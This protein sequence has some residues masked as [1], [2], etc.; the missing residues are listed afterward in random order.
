MERGITME[1]QTRTAGALGMTNF[2]RFIAIVCWW[3]PFV[4]LISL[5]FGSAPRSLKRHAKW[6]VLTVIALFVAALVLGLLFAGVGFL[7]SGNRGVF[8]GASIAGIFT[9]LQ[10]AAALINTVAILANRGPYFT[11]AGSSGSRLR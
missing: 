11:S 7:V 3:Q 1:R 8:A 4:A 6:V 5:F 9:F 10:I 2:E